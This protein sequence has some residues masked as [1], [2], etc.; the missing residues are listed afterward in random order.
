MKFQFPSRRWKIEILLLIK[1]SSKIF[2]YFFYNI[3][4]LLHLKVLEISF[5][6]SR[7]F[8]YFDDSLLQETSSELV[9]HRFGV[10]VKGHVELH[11]SVRGAAVAT[12][13]MAEVRRV[14]SCLA[15]LTEYCDRVW[16]CMPVCSNSPVTS[17]I[18]LVF[19]SLEAHQPYLFF[20]LYSFF[21]HYHNFNF[22]IQTQN[23]KNKI[24][25]IIIFEILII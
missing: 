6:K 25:S 13:H 5:S 1:E 24:I 14:W 3:H 15:P 20:S 17:H 8:L 21:V 10:G 16:W 12:H 22:F 4:P 23:F 18:A 2:T 19:F 7:L 9:D 11:L